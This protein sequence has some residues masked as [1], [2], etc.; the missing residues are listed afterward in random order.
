LS[1]CTKASK[2]CQN[3]NHSLALPL[4]TG[5]SMRKLP[6]TYIGTDAEDASSWTGGDTTGDDLSF[7]IAIFNFAIC[8]TALSAY[9]NA[10][11][12]S[13]LV[14]ASGAAAASYISVILVSSLLA[15][16]I[17]SAKTLRLSAH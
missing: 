10:T 6:F 1:L 11:V 7:S 14:R 9:E 13:S 15:K 16:L 3:G 12:T 4:N 5:I 2:F 8:V 17:R